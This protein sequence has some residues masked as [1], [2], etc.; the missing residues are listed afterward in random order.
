MRFEN[1]CDPFAQREV[2]E[3]D[4]RRGDLWLDRRIVSSLQSDAFEEFGFTD[5]L[6]FIR[7][8]V[9]ITVTTFDG[10]CRHNVVA[11][12]EI[13]AQ[14]VQQVN[15]RHPLPQVMMRVANRQLGL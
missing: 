6:H 10:D 5:R 11:T 9:A 12:G 14:I 3:T 7:A 2:G 8:I 4:D 15:V 1:R 13:R